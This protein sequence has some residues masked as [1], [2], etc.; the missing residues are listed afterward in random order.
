MRRRKT[1]R[2]RNEKSGLHANVCVT[3]IVILENNT[4]YSVLVGT[5]CRLELKYALR[6]YIYLN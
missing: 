3:G 1:K 2:E 6:L 5:F 4:L